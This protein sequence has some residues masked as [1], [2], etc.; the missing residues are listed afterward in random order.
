MADSDITT[1]QMTK[2]LGY[3][4][5]GFGVAGMLAP[6]ALRRSYGLGKSDPD[7]ALAYLGRMWG[8][9]T[10]V[11]GAVALGARSADEQRRVLML[12]AGM[13]AFDALTAAGTSAL[14]SRT[15]AMGALTSGFFAA[16][17]AYGATL[18]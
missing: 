9:R 1:D 16:T 4:S 6:S 2:V 11:L 15:R 12:A 7:G 13:N 8:T 14:P 10:L 18:D 3:A 17:S 5:V